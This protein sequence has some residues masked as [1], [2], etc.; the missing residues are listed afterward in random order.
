MFFVHCHCTR[1]RDSFC[2]ASVFE[3]TVYLLTYL[4]TYLLRLLIPVHIHLRLCTCC[5]CSLSKQGAK[6]RP[7]SHQL[8]ASHQAARLLV[9]RLSVIRHLPTTHYAT[10]LRMEHISSLPDKVPTSFIKWDRSL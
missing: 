7:S 3:M 1:F 10:G 8:L 6:T 2:L 9:R 4:L 5:G